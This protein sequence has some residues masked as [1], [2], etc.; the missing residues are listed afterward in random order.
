M[1]NNVAIA[2]AYALSV[3]RHSGVRRV[4]ILDFDVHHGNGT[5]AGCGVC[6]FVW[7]AAV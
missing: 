1:F 2:A 7:G 6:S 3:H 5:G 4:A